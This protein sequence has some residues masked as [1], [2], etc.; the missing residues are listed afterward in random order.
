MYRFIVAVTFLLFHV[1]EA[2]TQI[3]LLDE[4][5]SE[6]T[7]KSN[8][9][10]TFKGT[11]VVN[12]HSVEVKPSGALEFIIS[13]RFGALNS[14]GYNLWGLDFS[15][16]R[17]GLEYGIT[18]RLSIAVGRNSL[19]KT[20][21]GYLK[22][23][24]LS[25][26][27]TG[28]PFTVTMQTTAAYRSSY[29][30]QFS[31]LSR[32]DAM[33]YSAQALVARK[34]KTFSLQLAP[35]ILHRNTVDQDIAEN[36]LLALGIGGRFKITKSLALHGEYYARFNERNENPNYNPIGIAIDIETG[37]HV[38]QL[39][40]T[41]S[42]GMTDRIFVAETQGNFWNGDIHFGFNITR[43]FQLARK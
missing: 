1:N 22:Y 31:E 26:Q 37:G 2:F 14:G 9:L 23:K 20:Y 29:L 38:F 30:R 16:I 25:Q 7:E 24:V 6:Q 13:H 11:R 36:T 18:D 5:T 3:D 28:I 41:N 8:T 10:S 33:A 15:T 17:L 39:I 19:D 42:L 35:T 4:L 21:D 32:A 40:F 27:V 43:T 34:F 12:G